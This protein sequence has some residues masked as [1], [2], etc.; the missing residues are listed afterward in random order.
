MRIGRK[1][2]QDTVTCNDE[3]MTS[4]S[5]EPL[6]VDRWLWYTRFFKTRALASAA[7]KGGHI[8]V[9]GTKARPGTKVRIGD[10]VQIVRNQL[11]HEV[12]I[13]SIPLRRGPASEAQASYSESKESRQ[14]RKDTIS[15]I[16]ADRIRMPTTDGKPDKRT[17][18]KVRTHNRGQV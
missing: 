6:R 14:R 16:R 10:R 17:R 13:V 15:S 18:R 2:Y 4:H 7:V 8:R 9:S 3:Y 5:G 1:V 12:E 11:L